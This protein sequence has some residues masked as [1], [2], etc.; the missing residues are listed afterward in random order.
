MQNVELTTFTNAL[1]AAR[2]SAME[3]FQTSALRMAAAGVVAV[4]MKEGPMDF[5]HHAIGFT[6]YGTA[7]RPGP[8]GHRRQ[9]PMVAV[10]LNDPVKL[11]DAASLRRE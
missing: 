7:V 4:R 5:A 6:V 11:F 3:R 8:S 10:S 9:E 2:E 1:Y